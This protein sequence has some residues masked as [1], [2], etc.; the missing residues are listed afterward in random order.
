M[1]KGHG[2]L[3]RTAQAVRDSCVWCRAAASDLCMLPAA[4]TAA[5]AC[6]RVL[7]GHGNMHAAAGCM[8]AASTYA[9]RL[10]IPPASRTC[11]PT[12]KHVHARP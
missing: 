8:L 1:L 12:V 10:V 3:I 11:M 9:L 6:I 7:L 4:D 2:R 5:L